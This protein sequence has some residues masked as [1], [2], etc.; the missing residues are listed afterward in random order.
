M[1]VTGRGSS[2]GEVHRSGGGTLRGGCCTG[3]VHGTIHGLHGVASGRRTTGLCPAMRGLL[4]GLTGVGIVRRGGTTGLGSNL[5]RRVTGLTWLPDWD[6][7]SGWN[8]C[9]SWENY[10]LA[11]FCD[12]SAF[13]ASPPCF[14]LLFHW[15]SRE[16]LTISRLFFMSLRKGGAVLGVT[17]GRGAT[18]GCSTDGV[19]IL[20]NLRTIHGHPTVCVKSVSRGNL[21]RLMGRAISGSVSRTVT[22]CY[23]SVRIAVGRSGSVAMRSG[24]HNVPI[25]VRRGLRGSTLRIIVA[26]LRTNNGFSGNSC[27]ISK[28][29]RN[30]NMDYMGTLSARVLSRIFHNNGV[31]RRRCRG[32]GPLCSM[33]IMNRAGG[34]NAHRRF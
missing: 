20:R 18:G 22:N 25:S 19:R 33:G 32:K 6:G 14:F 15:F 28:N 2:M 21:R 8:Y 31:C 17:R 24:N 30:I 3:A 9:P 1:R 26:I 7:E 34:H 10:D 27:G 12:P 16:G 29:L 11:L 4:S 23:A 5:A 13:S